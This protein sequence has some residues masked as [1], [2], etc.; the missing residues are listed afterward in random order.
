M[1]EKITITP[2]SRF[3]RGAW[4]TLILVVAFLL[5]CL[6]V[7][8]FRFSLPLD[9][10]LSSEPEGFDSYGLIYKQNVMG[11]TSDLRVGDHLI[12][13][14]GISLDNPC[15]LSLFGLRS[16]WQAGNSVLYKVDRAGQVMDIR[17]PLVHWRWSIF[18]RS[19]DVSLSFLLTLWGFVIFQGMGF[20]AFVKRPD[21]PAARALLVLGACILG[22]ALAFGP[23]PNQISDAIYPIANLSLIILITLTFNLLLPP[24]LIR[25]SLVFPRPK[26]MLERWPW[27]AYL[28]YII[29]FIGV[30]AFMKGFFVYG[31]AWMAISTLVTILILI[32]N[33]FTL[34]DAVSRAQIRWGL[35]G[36]LIG[37][38]IFFSSYVTYFVEL[39]QPIAN[40]I[41]S[42][43]A[44]GIGMMGIGLG[45]AIL[46]YRLFDIDVIIR[47]TLQYTLLTGLL[48]LVYFG[49]VLLGQRIA[50]ALTG[51]Q[52]S[53]L[54]VVISTL[55]VAALFSRLR[56]RVQDF[57]DRRFY[58]QKY[59]AIQTLAAFTEVA[60]DE[61]R[62]EAL[63]PALL[64]AVQ[65]S[66]QPEQ[67]WLWLK[68]NQ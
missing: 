21:I 67:V 43:S 13:V 45:I 33:A 44:L 50:G 53:P 10:W 17:V 40:F 9:G 41:N 65:D 4:L 27:V 22:I 59:D 35:G 46:R 64:Q 14:E 6:A 54:V 47:R 52:N 2:E 48:A 55:L 23:G 15:Q 61:T 31:Y 36:S 32:H 34:K 20:V 57:I 16:R 18:I 42:W 11:A 56:A 51:E 19:I 26:G 5:F 62:L 49:S 7:L 30:A 28:P 1:T 12:A 25:F 66:V 39:P 8:G 63:S 38:G 24:A 68:N 58:R 29:G 37:L 3:D 60:R